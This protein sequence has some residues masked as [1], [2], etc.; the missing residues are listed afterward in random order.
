MALIKGIISFPTLFTP[1]VAKGADAAKFGCSILIPPNDP[2]IAALNAEVAAAKANGCPS[3]YHGQDECF[4]A[5]DVKYAGKDYYDPRFAGWYIFSCSAKAEDRPSVVDMN[6]NP[7]I[8][9]GAVYGGMVVYVNAGI[10][11]Y[12]KGK[13]GIGGWLNGVMITAEDL[14]MG[15]LDNKPSV[16]QMFSAVGVGTTA[17]TPA[18][19]ATPAPNGPPAPAPEAPKP[20]NVMTAKATFTYEQYIGAGHTDATLIKEGLM[21]APS[22]A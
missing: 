22:F 21:I 16:E 10:S 8:D 12:D 5:Y 2:Q 14:P 15:R 7:I 18:P 17:P 6:Y 20:A 19:N 11:Y 3:G 13:A 1:K 4:G 9:P